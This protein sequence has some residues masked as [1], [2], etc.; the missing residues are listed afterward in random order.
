MADPVFYPRLIE[1][2]L[3]EALEDAP[4]VLIHGPRQCGKTTLAQYG[5]APKHLGWLDHR[6]DEAA[7]ESRDYAY[8][9]F[10]DTVAREGAQADPV[11][12][13]AGLPERAILDEVQRVPEIFAALKAE[14]DRH[15]EPGRFILTGSSNVLL[16]PTLSDSLAGRMEIVR[17]HPLAQAEL[18]GVDAKGGFLDALF[19]GGFRP[20]QSKRL[21]PELAVRIVSGG[22]PAALA[23]PEGRRQGNWYRNY[24]ET[25][26]Q[27]DVRDLAHIRRPDALAALLSAAA[28]QTA[29]LYNLSELGATLQVTRPTVAEYVALLERLFLVD[30]L[31]PW[32]SN[33]LNRLVKTPKLHI[34][35]TGLA[36]A[37]LSLDAAALA[38]DRSLL[39]RLL[40]TF[41]LQELKRQAS[42]SD[43]DT[44]FFQFRDR[45]G[46]EVDIVMQR[47]PAA[48]A[49]VEVKASA[50]V[51]RSDFR[52]LRKLADALGERF[53]AG[54]VL[55]DGESVVSFGDRLKA[56]PIC[57]LWAPSANVMPVNV[58][59]GRDEIDRV[60]DDL[61]PQYGAMLRR[62]AE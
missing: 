25:L 43:T 21:G 47:G 52:S 2:R 1:A 54:V 27:R 23:R 35:D 50:T 56:V 55:Y 57:R 31:L 5:Y 10:D 11:G 18:A 8:I 29:R 60:F 42:W 19:G 9:T 24:I 34:G 62:L 26:V 61:Q 28:S 39:G 49:G 44:E 59:V 20:G 48:L 15:R 6:A 22:F 58:G 37:L 3:A 33:R 36:A 53:V 13:V 38:A 45:D 51:T 16:V 7:E 46:A 4:V 17:L 41:V 30:P 40:E 14:V 12:F 32:H